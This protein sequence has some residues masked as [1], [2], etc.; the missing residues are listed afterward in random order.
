MK[1]VF[2]FI[3]FSFA[4]T[5]LFVNIISFSAVRY[6]TLVLSILTV[7]SFIIKSIR[8]ARVVPVIL[9]SCT[10]ACLL[11][12]FVYS[13]ITAPQLALDN[14]EAQASL[15]LTSVGEENGS[16][17]YNYTA[18]INQLD[19]NECSIKVLLHTKRQ[20][21]AEPF[22]IINCNIKLYSIAD[23]A[24]SSY[25]Y[26]ADNIYL[27]A[28]MGEGCSI[29][30]TESKPLQYYI[31]VLSQKIKAEVYSSLD[32]DVGALAVSILTGDK[33]R[34]SDDVYDDFKT[35]GVTHTVA[36]SG[37][38]TTL[39]CLSVY[40]IL[41]LLRCPKV[42]SAF[43][44][45]MTLL[46]YVA[47]A[48]F[49]K[50]AVRAGIMLSVML[51]AKLLSSKADALN[52]LG[53][54][55]FII[56]LNP[57]AVFDAGA[58]MSVCAVLGILVIYPE[59]RKKKDYESRLRKYILDSVVLTISV[60]LAMLPVMCMIFESI[61]LVGIILNCVIIPLLQL[62][63]ISVLLMLIFCKSMIFAFVP[64]HIAEFALSAMIWLTDVFSDAFYWMKLS[65]ND[66]FLL[67]ASAF[68]LIFI[69][70][71]L[72]INNAVSV[73]IT[74]LIAAVLILLS[75]VFSVYDNN[76]V[77][78]VNC[79]RS[80]G[81]VISSSDTVVA[82]NID[83]YSDFYALKNENTHKQCIM[84]FC[85][86]YS[87]SIK[88]LFSSAADLSNNSGLYQ[89]DDKIT[90]NVAG[91][92]IDITIFDNCFKLYEKNV[93]INDIMLSG[94]AISGFDKNILIYFKDGREV[95]YRYG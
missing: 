81:T 79:L 3:G 69:G 14:T 58:S 83:D 62:A 85:D 64:V 54:A 87:D 1:R 17:G 80:G 48:D 72:I 94:K 34:L 59:L 32:G 57:Y 56:C 47:V 21:D 28:S 49:S 51:L 37:L 70:L 4:I 16:G 19:G 40:Y 46:V 33:S 25:G 13:N 29:A 91:D 26:Y 89:L 18:R 22:D 75:S 84:I 31:I 15:V 77:V 86:A 92:K 53:I 27:S 20:L 7:I 6:F 73:K 65:A 50:S 8:Q 42:F 11:F 30:K 95:K 35:C 9:C 88:S 12:S 74:S 68:C 23:N 66:S 82:V 43:L 38:H 76:T 90:V 45:I 93:I 52:S 2:A 67:T 71:A 78:T 39:I 36:V 63:L 60:T 10:I 55:V 61:S 24:Y 44:T 5:L 41:K